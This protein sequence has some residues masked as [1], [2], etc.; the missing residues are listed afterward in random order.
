[1]SGNVINLGTIE[2][3]T[4]PVPGLFR[5]AGIGVQAC[6]AKTNAGGG[7][8]GRQ[9]KNQVV[10]DQFN[11]NQARAAATKLVS[12][13]FAFVGSA[14]LYDGAMAAPME[15]AGMPDIG[16]ALQDA[17]RTS[18]LNWSP[19]PNPPGWV[20]G[21]LS[22]LKE[23]FPAASQAVGLLGVDVAA[24]A[25]DG[26]KA[27]LVKLGY[28]LVYDQ[29]YGATTTDFTAQVFRMKSSGVRMLAMTG[30]APSYA[31][32]LQAANQQAL[33][34]DVFNPISNAYDVRFQQIAGNLTEGTIIYSASV[35]YAGED[36]AAVPAVADFNTWMRRVE[37][38]FTP[39]VFALYGWL[40]CE[41]FVQAATAIGPRLTRKAMRDQ[42]ATVTRFDGR[43]L[44]APGNPAGKKASNCYVLFQVTRGKWVRRDTPPDKFRC[45]GTYLYLHQ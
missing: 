10:D 28:K 32:V 3:L 9:L 18:A 23:K 12:S 17:R 42:L 16:E 44:I 26:L 41:M 39:E 43:G 33:K 45:D 22:Y 11:E 2:T 15:R 36:A 29:R 7:L 31:R 24:E 40:S 27:A 19:Q 6:V 13:A 21:G 34:L 38:D 35:A 1:V 37:P 14:S 25:N 4:G 5:G 8:F 20:T 30:D